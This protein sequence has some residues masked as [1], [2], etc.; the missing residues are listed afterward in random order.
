MV[1]MFL[2]MEELG[3]CFPSLDALESNSSD[4]DQNKKG[5]WELYEEDTTMCLDLLLREKKRNVEGKVR[6]CIE[7]DKRAMQGR[8]EESKSTERERW[9][10]SNVT[11]GIARD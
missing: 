10:R 5:H 2:L 11:N 7:T 6:V 9:E 3:T 4:S 1:P 8:N